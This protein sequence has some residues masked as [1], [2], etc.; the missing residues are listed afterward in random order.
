M[1]VEANNTRTGVLGNRSVAASMP[2]RAIQKERF[3]RVS[4][5]HGS[6]WYIFSIVRHRTDLSLHFL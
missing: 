5:H 6:S 2:F 3:Q 1:F 4:K